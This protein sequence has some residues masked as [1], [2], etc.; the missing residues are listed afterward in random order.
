M[1]SH[2]VFCLAANKVCE[3]TAA[4][5]SVLHASSQGNKVV[6]PYEAKS[7][8]SVQYRLEVSYFSEFSKY[9][10]QLN[11]YLQV[12]RVGTTTV[13]RWLN[14]HKRS[15]GALHRRSK[16]RTPCS[17]RFLAGCTVIYNV[18]RPGDFWYFSE[19]SSSEPRA[20]SEFNGL[21][22]DLI[23]HAQ[24]LFA[25]FLSPVCCISYDFGISTD[26]V[27]IH[28]CSISTSWQKLH[29]CI[30]FQHLPSVWQWQH[31]VGCWLVSQ[32]VVLGCLVLSYKANHVVAIQYWLLIGFIDVIE[33]AT[34]GSM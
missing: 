9:P 2:A 16:M 8:P 17:L 12:S 20:I 6:G 1:C 32:S 7:Q 34:H 28:A 26:M 5:W 30:Q 18:T 15:A 3:P 31:N 11:V 13:T 22:N 25:L 29:I 4:V 21:Q 14:C 23:L 24:L 33:N 19:S 27:E 10:F